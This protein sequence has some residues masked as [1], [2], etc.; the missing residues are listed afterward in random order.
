MIRYNSEF[1]VCVCVCVGV[2]VHACV[3]ACVLRVPRKADRWRS[4]WSIF[5]SRTAFADHITC[6]TSIC[7]ILYYR[8]LRL[9]CLYV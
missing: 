3:C 9:G 8:N 1:D 6:G 7:N 4:V 2:R 5:N